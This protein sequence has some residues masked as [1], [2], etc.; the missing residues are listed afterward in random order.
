MIID[1]S[2]DHVNPIEMISIGRTEERF[3]CQGTNIVAEYF[4]RRQGLGM[5]DY[6]IKR[7]GNEFVVYVGDSQVL[8]CASRREAEHAIRNASGDAARRWY[9]PPGL[10]RALN[11][12]RNASR[13]TD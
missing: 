3:L 10:V 5:Q 8:K 12:F 13:D 9:V 11:Y 6:K 1:L 4:L 7:A 2:F